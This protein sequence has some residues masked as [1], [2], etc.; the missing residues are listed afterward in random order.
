MHTNEGEQDII[1]L[2]LKAYYLFYCI[3]AEI[4]A[5]GWYFVVVILFTLSVNLVEHFYLKFKGIS[6]FRLW[7]N[8]F[9]LLDGK[10]S[11]HFLFASSSHCLLFFLRHFLFSS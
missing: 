6:E 10:E 5:A 3:I 11:V 2:R 7:M 8:N 9:S 1:M 4:T